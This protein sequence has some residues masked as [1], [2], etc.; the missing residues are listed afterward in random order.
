MPPAVF[1]AEDNPGDVELLRIALEESQVTCEL[2][3]A[4][5]GEKALSFIHE[6]GTGFLVCPALAIIDLNLP[7]RNGREVLKYL[8]KSPVCNNVPIVILSSSG[9]PK[10]IADTAQLG[11]SEY[12]RK[13]SSL[14]GFLEMGGALK[15]FIGGV[16]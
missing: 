2:Y 10:D 12:I 4:G 3:V 16:A 9:S 7:K 15:R 1:V 6:I 14:E 11:A 13:P 8:R 5:D